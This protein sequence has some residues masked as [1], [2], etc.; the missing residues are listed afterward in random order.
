MRRALLALSAGQLHLTRR[1][2][3]LRREIST[4]RAIVR[5]AIRTGDALSTIARHDDTLRR[6]ETEI[7]DIRA[8]LHR[9]VA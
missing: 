9:E 4:Q 3:E 6:L 2:L 1:E 5:R 8:V 7:A